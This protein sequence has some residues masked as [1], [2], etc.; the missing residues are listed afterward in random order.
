MTKKKNAFL[1]VGCAASDSSQLSFEAPSM[2]FVLNIGEQSD[3]FNINQPV[4]YSS[5]TQ[6]N[7]SNC[8]VYS[9]YQRIEILTFESQT[10]G[11]TT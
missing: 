5:L 7:F 9:T 8:H 4:T 2:D 3:P 6:G 11:E 10:D 1:F